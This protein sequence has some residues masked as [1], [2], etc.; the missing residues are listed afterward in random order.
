MLF[1]CA[2][3]SGDANCPVFFQPMY[4]V[5]INETDATQPF[6][7]DPV[8]LLSVQ[9]SGTNL[10]Y[11]LLKEDRAPV[12][13]DP[14]TGNISATA[15]LDYETVTNYTFISVCA[16]RN[17]SNLNATAIVTVNLLPVNEHRPVVS[18]SVFGVI[19]CTT[20]LGPLDILQPGV[21]YTVS[22][23]DRP[24][25]PIYFIFESKD[26]Y[27][28]TFSFNE[29]TGG[30]NLVK[31]IINPS[32]VYSFRLIICDFSSRHPNCPTHVMLV[33]YDRSQN[34]NSHY[35]VFSQANYS[36]SVLESIPVNTTLLTVSC[37]DEDIC[38]GVYGGMEIVNGTNIGDI[39]SLDQ[40]GNIKNMY[41]LDF[42]DT[43]SYNFQVR[44]YDE[45]FPQHSQKSTF[46]TVTITI[47]DA[48]DNAPRCFSHTITASLGVGLYPNRHQVLHIS[49][50]DADI[51]VN[52]QLTYTVQGELPTVS[53]GQFN[54]DPATGVLT[55][56]GEVLSTFNGHY[57]IDVVVAD[58]GDT[59]LTA[60]VKVMVNITEEP[61]VMK[62]PMQV[63]LVV[64][65]VGVF[66]LL[67]CC[68]GI[69]LIVI[70][71]HKTKYRR[72]NKANYRM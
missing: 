61:E 72:T 66:L 20:P 30:F 44:C 23:N 9:C 16:A 34:Q 13:I 62:F 15:A 41:P 45:P 17:D 60:R 58:S 50:E 56:T 4:H 33:A 68:A 67:L 1:I 40:N 7:P 11:S 64:C 53:T 51:G 18:G 2:D 6:P 12:T 38:S 49:C 36:T 26:T 70:C 3:F 5:S 71:L 14:T 63:V 21:L 39:F 46:S 28:G 37:T 35:P 32:F 31:R 24:K 43:Q 65:I 8:F 22:D 55:F 42:E 59:P 19:N 10:T 27:N 52:S 29:T 47:L 57:E 69:L 48:N 54:L 25:G